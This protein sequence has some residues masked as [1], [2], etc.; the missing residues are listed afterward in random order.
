MSWLRAGLGFVAAMALASCSIPNVDPQAE[1]LAKSVYDQ[2][3]KGDDAAVAKE[4]APQAQS[5]ML[6]A[7]LAELRTF[8]PPGEPTSVTQRGLNISAEIGKGDSATYVFAYD[9]PDRTVLSQITLF[10]PSSGVPWTVLGFHVNSELKGAQPTSA[11]APS[12][13]GGSGAT[14]DPAKTAP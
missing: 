8:I 3:R 4:M 13:V 6:G 10:R 5:P 11:P 7:Q 1:A 9:Y 2:V 12:A 14:T